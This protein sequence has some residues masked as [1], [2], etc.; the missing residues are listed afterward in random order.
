MKVAAEV[1]KS[2]GFG[3]ILS[4]QGYLTGGGRDKAARK[5]REKRRALAQPWEGLMARRRVCRKCGWCETVRLDTLSGME[6]SVPL[7]VSAVLGSESSSRS[8]LK[9]IAGRDDSRSQHWAVP[10]TRAT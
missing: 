4:L 1:M 8:I 2:R 10:R 3:E 6:L 5:V 7:Y 9:L